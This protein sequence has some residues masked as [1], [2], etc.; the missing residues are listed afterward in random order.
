MR[1]PVDLEASAQDA[2]PGPSGG[3]DKGQ[4]LQAVRRALRAALNA[5]GACSSRC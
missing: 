3:T 5:E 2:A 1:C 4:D